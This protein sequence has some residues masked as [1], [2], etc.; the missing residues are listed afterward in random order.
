SARLVHGFQWL[1]GTA[2][3]LGVLR[4]A[5]DFVKGMV[6]DLILIQRIT[7]QNGRFRLREG[8]SHAPAILG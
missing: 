7:W 3:V 6:L 1:I 8:P 4:F 2:M 5:I